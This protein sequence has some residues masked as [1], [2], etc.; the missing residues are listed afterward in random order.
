MSKIFEAL[1]NARPEIRE[2]GPAMPPETVAPSLQA[3]RVDAGD[4]EVRGLYQK[5]DALLSDLPRKIVMFIGSR[6]GEG[7]STIV[8]DYARTAA[9][10]FAKDTLILD[11]DPWASPGR[12]LLRSVP[13]FGWGDALAEPG[14][15]ERA[16]TPTEEA[17]LFFSSMAPNTAAPPAPVDFACFSTMLAG[18]R[19]RF[20]LI[21]I[22]SAPAFV[23]PDGIAIA[24]CADG[25]ILIVEADATRCHAARRVIR[26]LESCGAH[27]LGTVLN[28]KR[29]YIP[30]CIERRL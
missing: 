9:T 2:T 11:A 20:D 3:G 12:G 13:E 23:Y 14:L 22:D 7:T 19:S 8:Q 10:V 24:R 27:I 28:K 29:H 4:R 17:H 16:L 26:Q 1:Q 5:V 30:E 15:I 6:E 18:L 25:V 21:V